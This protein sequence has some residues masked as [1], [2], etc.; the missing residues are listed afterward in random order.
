M[1]GIICACFCSL[2]CQ[3]QIE[4]EPNECPSGYAR[5]DPQMWLFATWQIS[6]IFFFR[7]QNKISMFLECWI[8]SRINKIVWHL[9]LYCEHR[10]F[11][12][13]HTRAS[14]KPVVMRPQSTKKTENDHRLNEY[15]IFYMPT[16]MRP[17][18][19]SILK[20]FIHLFALF[21]RK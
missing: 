17:A 13:Q 12:T 2:R 6:C 11:I 10:N 20:I 18:F 19:I 14:C 8:S 9:L 4:L 7:N 1:S 3:K 16:Q 15:T 21:W 5:V